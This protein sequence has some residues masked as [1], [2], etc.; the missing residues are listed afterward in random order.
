MFIISE[1][2]WFFFLLFLYMISKPRK[3]S[4]FLP[5]NKSPSDLQKLEANFVSGKIGIVKI[6]ITFQ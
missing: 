4:E 2:Y 5:W 1:G 3:I 6:Y